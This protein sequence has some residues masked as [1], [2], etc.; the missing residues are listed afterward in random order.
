MRPAVE[1]AADEA[2]SNHH[3]TPLTL[4]VSAAASLQPACTHNV[5]QRTA[6][7]WWHQVVAR[8]FYLYG[9]SAAHIVASE[10][11]QHPHL[12]ARY[13]CRV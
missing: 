4:H 10:R 6:T 13:C 9:E 11:R 7:I 8:G 1:T 3:R 2:G 5:H 12:C